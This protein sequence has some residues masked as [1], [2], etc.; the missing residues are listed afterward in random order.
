M[1]LLVEAGKRETVPAKE[2][3]AKCMVVSDCVAYHWSRTCICEGGVFSSPHITYT[4][5]NKAKHYR[6]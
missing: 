1:L 2:K 6:R 4:K 5:F 3:V